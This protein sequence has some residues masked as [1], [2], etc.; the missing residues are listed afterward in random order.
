MKNAESC[1][2]KLN[3]GAYSLATGHDNDILLS[4]K[5]GRYKEY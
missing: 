2:A 3:R 4:N 1:S 5:F